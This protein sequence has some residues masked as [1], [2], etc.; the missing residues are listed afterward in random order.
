MIIFEHIFN[1]FGLWTGQF[2][3]TNVLLLILIFV[4]CFKGVKK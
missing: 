3:L 2:N 4:V 1:F